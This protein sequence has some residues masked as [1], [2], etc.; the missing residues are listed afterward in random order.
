MRLTTDNWRLTT[1]DWRLMTAAALAVVAAGCASAPPAAHAKPAGPAF[2]QKMAWI[3]RLE[4]Q[5]VLRDPAP[6]VTPPAP[7]AV[8]RGQKP[9]PVAAPPQPPDLTRLLSDEEARVRR[10]AALAIGH[11]GLADG[12]TPL[13]AG[14]SDADPEVRQ[15]AAFA[16]GLLG[17]TRARDPLIAALAD[18]APVVQGSAAEALGL[19]GD[20]PAADALGR[21]AARIIGSGALAQPPDENDDTRRDTATAACRLA[22]HALVRLKAYPQLAS[23][24]LDA[25]GQP[26]AH[27][28]PVAFALQRLED[29]RALPAL[30][31]LARDGNA[32]TRAFAVKGLA[33][34]KDRSA[35]PVLLPLLTSGDRNV[36]VETVRA[37]GRIGDPA[38]AAPLLKILGDAATDPQVRLETV[39]AIGAL[40]VPAV[41]DAL[42]DVLADPSPSIRAAALRSLAAFDPENF[43]FVLS[44]LD[45][46]PHWNVRAA[47]ATLLGGLPPENGL[48]RLEPMV[49]DPDQRV[50]PFAIAA[51]AKLKAPA[52]AAL[53]VERLK[54]DDPVVR[55]AAADAVGELKPANGAAALADAYRF[56]QRDAMYGARAAALAALVKYGAGAAAPVLRDAFADKDW[57]V[58]VRA[59]QLLKQLDPAAAAGADAQIRPAPTTIGGEVYAAPRL[60]SPPVSTQV[61]LDTDRGTIQIELAVNDAPL[62]VENFIA[63]ARKGYFNGLSVHRVVPDFVIQD[64]DPRGD[65]EGGPGYSIRDE[66][67]E[68]PYLRGTVGMALDPWPDTGGSQ[69]FIT[70]SPQPHLDAKYTVFGR[71]V[72]GMDVVDKIQQWDV[73]RAVRVWDGQT[74][75]SR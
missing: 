48:P 26:R 25:N 31:T 73:I 68:R 3:L 64:G 39:S 70:H 27:W 32:Y 8:A 44:G 66:L 22:I 38:A 60:V 67:N 18:P 10:R 34:L 58:R 53:A 14:L 52:A 59:V 41:G 28:W 45:P 51:L 47:L 42:L 16:L 7:V 46:D 17:D 71:V 35:L 6:I 9:Q 29:P 37:L 63:L 2:E 20:A 33:A 21:F 1:D 56:G 55:I 72:S 36:L 75:T 5:R 4:D 40:H 12:V 62:T 49:N 61:Y 11:V 50:I 23:A 57:A 19:I 65:G 54:A 69:Y 24:V 30:L 74:M 13:L 15:M 43:I